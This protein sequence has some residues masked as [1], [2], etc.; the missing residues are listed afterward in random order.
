MLADLF[1]KIDVLLALDEHGLDA[2]ESLDAPGGDVAE[3]RR[4][5]GVSV[6]LGQGLASPVPT[7]LVE[8]LK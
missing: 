8:P 4:T 6:D 3:H 5:E 2:G 7:S 1:G